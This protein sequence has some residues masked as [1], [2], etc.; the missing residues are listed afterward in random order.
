MFLSG[1]VDDTKSECTIDEGSG[2]VSFCLKK[3]V[4]GPL[5]E[6]L[7]DR[8]LTKEEKSER[9]LQAVEITQQRH[10]REQEEKQSE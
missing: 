5:W 9:R 2:K 3:A 1:E 8:G 4:A 6:K 10:K 7:E